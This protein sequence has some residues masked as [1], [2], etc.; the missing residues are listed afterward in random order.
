MNEGFTELATQVVLGTTDDVP[1]PLNLYSELTSALLEDIVIYHDG[2]LDAAKRT[3]EDSSKGIPEAQDDVIN[4]VLE[5][6]AR[7]DP[8]NFPQPEMELVE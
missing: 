2:D 4:A 6:V 7:T 5:A 3:I 8:G 1:V